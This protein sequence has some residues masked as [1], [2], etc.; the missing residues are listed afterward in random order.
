MLSEM[1]EF[2]KHKKDFKK[3]NKYH[4]LL[5]DSGD[6]K[7]AFSLKVIDGRKSEYKRQ[8]MRTNDVNEEDD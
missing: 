3:K 7:G 1:E 8:K 4:Q 2:S 5:R 6:F